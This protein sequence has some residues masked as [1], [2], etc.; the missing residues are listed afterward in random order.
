MTYYI[1][2][3]PLDWGDLVAIPHF[4]ITVE[5]SREITGDETRVTAALSHVTLGHLD[6]VGRVD[7][8][9]LTAVQAER[10]WGA[11]AVD[12]WE[13]AAAEGFDADEA[14]RDEADGR[15]DYQRAMR[16]DAA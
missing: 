4:D 10:I 12:A 8:I 3:D 13:T 9:D 6:P 16:E 11:D 1:E 15:A 14:M 7:G 5:T 2:A